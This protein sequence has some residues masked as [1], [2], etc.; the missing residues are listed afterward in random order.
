MVVSTN[1]IQEFCSFVDQQ[2]QRV[3]QVGYFFHNTS[4][5][6]LLDGIAFGWIDLVTKKHSYYVR[7]STHFFFA[8]S[9][10]FWVD[11]S[12]VRIT[13]GTILDVS[14]RQKNIYFEWPW[15]NEI[16][17]YFMFCGV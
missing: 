13:W 15:K 7:P 3:V 2:T 6:L 10:A 5:A 8:T 17:K 1:N 16:N 12:K 14:S 9:Y 11:F 4:L